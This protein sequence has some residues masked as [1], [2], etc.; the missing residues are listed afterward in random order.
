MKENNTVQIFVYGSLRSGFHSPAYNYVSKYFTLVGAAKTKGLLI[1]MGEYPV[2]I[3]T[4]EDKFLIGELYQ[5]THKEAFDFAIAQLDDYEGVNVEDGEEQLYFRSIT[6]VFV[7][8]T[9]T[10]AWVYW[11]KGDTANKPIVT[12]GDVLQYMEEKKNN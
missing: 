6:E 2:A 12:S 11:F 5:I 10:T 8:D 1:D 3:A 9:T 7:N 4:T